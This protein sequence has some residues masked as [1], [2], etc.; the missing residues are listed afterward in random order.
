M[1]NRREGWSRRGSRLVG[2]PVRRPQL[3]PRSLI[4]MYILTYIYL[5]RVSVET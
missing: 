3:P 2:S 4:Y 1:E 5:T